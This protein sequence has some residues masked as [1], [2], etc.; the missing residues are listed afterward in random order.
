VLEHFAI[1]SEPSV[2]VSNKLVEVVEGSDNFE[3]EV[4]EVIA[5]CGCDCLHLPFVWPYP[6]NA[7][8]R[9]HLVSL[10]MDQEE[11]VPSSFKLPY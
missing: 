11:C 9:L 4:L 7:Y 6:R 3:I 5:L 2:G 8:Q 10:P 1:D